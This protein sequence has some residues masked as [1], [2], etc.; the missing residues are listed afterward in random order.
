V[1][2]LIEARRRAASRP[3]DLLSLLL[4]AQDEGTGAG[5]TDQ[6]VKDEALT[7][8][9][10]GHETVGAALSWAWYLLAQQPQAQNDLHD[11]ASARLQGRSPTAEDLPHLPLARAAFEEAMRLYPP[12]WGLP[13]EA[14]QADEI[15]GFAMPARGIIV[16]S[17]YVTHRHPDFWPEPDRFKPERFL[18]AQA[19]SRPKFAYFPFG[20]G[21][22][23]CIGNT[24]ALMEGPMVLATVLQRFRVELVADQ[25]VVPDPT[26]T[27][28]PRDGVKVVFWPR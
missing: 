23:V 22:R 11:E 4:E 10:A 12:A 27:L 9:T 24:F 20:G 28:R 17:Q 25:N 13:R 14:V 18:P 26:F 7:L 1:L 3:D 6:Q 5:M 8:L 2:E 21:P 16:L 19:A 15:N